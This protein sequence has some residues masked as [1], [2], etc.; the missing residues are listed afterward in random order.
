[1][2]EFARD[3]EREGGR[4]GLRRNRGDPHPPQF[5]HHFRGAAPAEDDDFIGNLHVIPERPAIELVK[6]IMAAD[7]LTE[8][9]D[10]PVCLIEQD[11]AVDAVRRIVGL[12]EMCEQLIRCREDILRAEAHVAR[13]L[14]DLLGAQL[15][16]APCREVARIFH[17]VRRPPLRIRSSS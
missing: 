17:R 11:A 13:P 6:D 8:D 10:F 5:E 2:T 7:V 14:K 9:E 12:G 15:Q 4:N 3:V 1:M 16:D